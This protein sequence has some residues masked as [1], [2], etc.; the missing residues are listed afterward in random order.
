MFVAHDCGFPNKII[1][2]PSARQDVWA[3]DD[4]ADVRLLLSRA[5]KRCFPPVSA[6][7][8][9]DG[10]AMIERVE[11]GSRVP[12]VVLLDY[13][14]PGL[15]GLQTVAA[16]QPY[17]HGETVVLMFSAVTNRETVRAA[18]SSGVRLFLGKP[19]NGH[20]YMTL[21]NLCAYCSDHEP[22]FDPLGSAWD[23]T[24]ALHLFTEQN[25]APIV[26]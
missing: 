8:F 11:H 6:E 13:Q 16:L 3:A 23:V 2:S 22:S 17:L 19:V 14:M 9:A 21:A 26:V 20:E 4:G 7:I 12:K 24:R 1:L 18:Y 25:P 10:A 5:F 15:D